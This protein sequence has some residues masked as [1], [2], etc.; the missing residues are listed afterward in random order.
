MNS[1]FRINLNSDEKNEDYR[2]PYLSLE[3]KLKRLENENSEL[4]EYINQRQSTSLYDNKANN[5]K[6][7]FF[8]L[9]NSE[10]KSQSTKNVGTDLYSG[11][12]NDK[13][14]L[15]DSIRHIQTDIVFLISKSL[16]DILTKKFDK[17][18]FNNALE[19]KVSNLRSRSEIL[20]TLAK[21][22]KLAADFNGSMKKFY[23]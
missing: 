8:D 5:W 7:P 16:D 3:H 14:H 15:N 11:I 2:E 20:S 23:R 1:H 6:I 17:R 19:K 9:E 13:T 10:N 4:K 21:I 22:D 18:I 12:L